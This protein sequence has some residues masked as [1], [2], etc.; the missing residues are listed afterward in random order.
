MGMYRDYKFRI[1]EEEINQ[2][3]LDLLDW[4]LER[5]KEQIKEVE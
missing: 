3:L 1:R 5:H 2:K 4:I